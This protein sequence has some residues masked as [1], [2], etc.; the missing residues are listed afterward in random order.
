MP[1]KSAVEPGTLH[2]LRV[3]V[4]D[5]NKTNRLIF[6]EMLSNW[7]MKPTSVDNGFTALREMEQAIK[8]RKPYQLVLLDAMMPHMD[9]FEVA[10]KIK[11]APGL[12]DSKLIMLSSAG[13]IPNTRRNE[14]GIDNYLMKPVK[15]SE[16]LD[17]I[18][19]IFSIATAD[20]AGSGE[21]VLEQV[22]STLTLNILLAEDG[23]INQKVAVLLAERPI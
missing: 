8:D 21:I 16:L 13:D 2:G 9:G 12:S 19:E 11:H 18:V 1:V 15:Q 20:E 7:L 10:E 5:D 22:E 3:L 14:L 17:S 6:E 23:L 4:V